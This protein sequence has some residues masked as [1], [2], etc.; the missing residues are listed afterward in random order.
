MGSRDGN[1]C[2]SFRESYRWCILLFTFLCYVSYHLSRKPI[3]VVKSVLHHKNCSTVP[4]DKTVNTTNPYWCDWAPFDST[5]Y[6]DMLGALDLSYLIAYAVAMFISGHIADR[7]DLR[8]YLSGGMIMSGIFTIGFGLGYFY[9][10]H[11]FAFYIIM[12]IIGGIFQATGWPGVVA[13]VGNWFGK[14]KRGL[15]MGIWNAHT[16]VGNILGSVIAGVFVEDSWG[17]SFVVP[18]LII[19]AVGILVFLLLVPRVEC[20]GT[21]A[22]G[23]DMTP[24]SYVPS[25]I[26]S[27]TLTAKLKLNAN[28]N[29]RLKL[30]GL[31]N[32][33]CIKSVLKENISGLQS[34]KVLLV[35]LVLALVE[36]E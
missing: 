1:E 13:C 16:S 8:Y 19:A 32:S 28:L 6:K 9:K 7:I 3:S 26:D 12:Q 27:I 17:W 22:K 11:S 25:V 2:E 35:V 29:S 21:T 15:I 5:N 18:G 33:N 31:S 36:S 4:H 10:I 14:G 24:L 30:Q 23:E 20:R 34:F